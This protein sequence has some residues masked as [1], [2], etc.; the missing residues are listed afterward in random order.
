[1]RKLFSDVLSSQ[2]KLSI[3]EANIA[4]INLMSHRNLKVVSNNADAFEN[5]LIGKES[6]HFIEQV[7][8]ALLERAMHS[9]T[10]LVCADELQT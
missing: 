4:V 5:L 2:P 10:D 9:N 7:Q 3:T 6:K 1:M 8:F